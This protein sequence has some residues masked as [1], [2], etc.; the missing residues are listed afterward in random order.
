VYSHYDWP[1]SKALVTKEAL[2]VWKKMAVLPCHLTN[3]FIII[4]HQGR[5]CIQ[6]VQ[7]LDVLG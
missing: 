6:I 4:I 1:F 7:Q 5:L 3:G 2:F